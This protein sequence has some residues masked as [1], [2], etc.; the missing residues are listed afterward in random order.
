M[1]WSRRCSDMTGDKPLCWECKHWSGDRADRTCK[2]FA[3]GIPQ[4]IYFGGFDHREAFEGDGGI[5]FEERDEGAAGG[6]D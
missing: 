5:R 6:L 2:A 4:E 1:W 3:E